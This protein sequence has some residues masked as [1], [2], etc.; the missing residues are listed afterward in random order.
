MCKIQ[1]GYSWFHWSMSIIAEDNI[2][3]SSLWLKEVL[4]TLWKKSLEILAE[5][6]SR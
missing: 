1:A 2:L 4:V 3:I 5:E 6:T